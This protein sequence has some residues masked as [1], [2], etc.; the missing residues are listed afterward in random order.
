MPGAGRD[1]TSPRLSGHAVSTE[2]SWYCAAESEE[3][4]DGQVYRHA[5][6]HVVFKQDGVYACFP[7]LYQYPDGTLA[8]I[9]Y[10]NAADNVTHVC[11]TRWT[12]PAE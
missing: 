3:P 9:Y 6:H 10:L 1:F 4:A 8:T 12:P 5:Q 2:I 11:L 7:S